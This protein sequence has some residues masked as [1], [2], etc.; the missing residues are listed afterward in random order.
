[1]P[2][3][4]IIIPVYNVEDYI[5]RTL[6]SIMKQTYQ[7][8]EVIIV[9]DGST[10]HSMDFVK[11]YP[12]KVIHQKHEGV[13]VARNIGVEKAKGEYLVFVDSD[14]FIEKD[15]LKNLAKNI[16]DQPDLVRFQVQTVTDQGEVTKYEEIPFFNKNG[17]DAFSLLS[18][19]H[20]VENAW[21][22][23]YRRKYY[24]QEKFAFQAHTVHEDFGLIPLVI[25]KAK[26]V[27]SISY[28][29]Y[30]YY[31][32]SGSIMNN[33]EDRFAKKKVN[34]FYHHYLFLKK[35][36]EKVDADTTIFKSFIANSMIL[37]IC[38]LNKKDYQLYLKRI[39]KK[40]VY[41]DLL[42]DTFQRKIK[43]ILLEISPRLFN[44]FKIR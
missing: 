19:Y 20:F 31:R 29:G 26:K 6:Q 37:K 36:I 24:Q 43:K 12:F 21:C 41:D 4:S 8:Y 9:D 33:H 34:D 27:H 18:K 10:D 22:Y 17:E 42:T 40:K 7:D 14:D 15:L 11:K 44:R 32:R 13:S 1:M 23:T 38:E 39:K 16:S 35:E 3:F 25:I 2:K 5:D 28:I 30:N